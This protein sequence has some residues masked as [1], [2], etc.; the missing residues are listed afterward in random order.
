MLFNS[1]VFLFYFLP[2][3]FLIYAAFELG[4]YR[5]AAKLW[6]IAASLFFYAYWSWQLIFLVLFSILLNYGISLMVSGAD[7]GRARLLVG[8]GIFTNLALLAFFKYA[9]FAVQIVDDASGLSLPMISIILPLAISFMTFQQIAFLV[10]RAR[11][12]EKELRLADYAFFVT[13]FPHL[14]AGPICYLRDIIPQLDKF[15]RGSDLARDVQAGLA[16]IGIGLFKKIV[17]S[18]EFQAIADPAFASG[19]PLDAMA[20]WRAALAFSLQ[21]YFDFSAYSDIALGLGVLF[22]VRLPLNFYSPYKAASIIEFWRTWHISLGRFLRDYLYI[23]LGG[24]R[25]GMERTLCNVMIVMVLAGLWHGANWTFVVWGAVHG[26]FLAVNHLYRFLRKGERENTA[27]WWIWS[28]RGATFLFVTLAWVLFRSTDLHAAHD[29]Y[30][31]LFSVPENLALM[32]SDFILIAGV[33]FCWFLPNVAQ[34][35]RSSEPACT[36]PPGHLSFERHGVP[37][38]FRINLAWGMALG[39]LTA[40]I[41]Q[42]SINAPADTFI[43]FQF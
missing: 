15:R 39:V 13:Y 38:S 28:C 29:F 5:R 1:K 27:A 17:L 14:I 30:G 21:I 2:T 18:G 3:V 43:Y 42:R 22:G 40:F 25:S 35:F 41:V 10:D 4:K 16:I 6:F 8:L 23:P 12:P 9:G 31:A 33:A 26:L 24:S 20:A 11:S 7:R 34:I 19:F 32:P 37:F 36:A